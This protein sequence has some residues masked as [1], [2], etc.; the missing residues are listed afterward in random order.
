MCRKF[1]GSIQKRIQRY[2][3]NRLQSRSK[4][5][6]SFQHSSDGLDLKRNAQ[7]VSIIMLTRGIVRANSVIIHCPVL[8][9]GANCRMWV[10]SWL[11]CFK[12]TSFV[13][14]FNKLLSR[15][16]VKR[17]RG[18]TVPSRDL[19]WPFRIVCDRDAVE[20]GGFFPRY[21]HGIL[22]ATNGVGRSGRSRPQLH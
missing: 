21:L 19:R 2:G 14:W 3:L 10:R 12:D 4:T 7:I 15:I 1:A 9:W 18:S 6:V 11:S 16:N 8:I 20:I 13:S 5:Q 17:N 22:T